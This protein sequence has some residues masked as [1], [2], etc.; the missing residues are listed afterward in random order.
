MKN[1]EE[2]YDAVNKCVTFEALANV[3]RGLGDKDGFIQG[4]T[5]KFNAEVMAR[6]CMNFSMAY[7]NTLTREFGIRQ[8]AMHITY[9]GERE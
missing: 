1:R 6:H 8:Q 5:R 3:I 4:R 9:Y 2:I 7:P